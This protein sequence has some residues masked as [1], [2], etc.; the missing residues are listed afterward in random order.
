MLLVFQYCLAGK[1]ESEK[2]VLAVCGKE[3]SLHRTGLGLGSTDLSRTALVRDATGIR[4]SFENSS[5]DSYASQL[6]A[7]ADSLR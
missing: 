1:L 2:F 7:F 3:V 4:G 6:V 5:C